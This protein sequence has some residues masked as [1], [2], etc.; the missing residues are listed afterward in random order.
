MSQGLPEG[1]AAE[2]K[3]KQEAAEEKELK[4]F[5]SSKIFEYKGQSN[6]FRLHARAKSRNRSQNNSN[7]SFDSIGGDN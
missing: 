2:A 3:K 5:M 1:D 6:W 4:E 7:R